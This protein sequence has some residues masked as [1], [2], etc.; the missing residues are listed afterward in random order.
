MF[1]QYHLLQKGTK[2]IPLFFLL[3]TVLILGGCGAQTAPK[4]YRVGIV[5]GADAFAAIGDGFKDKMTELGYN[6]GKNIVYDF[7]KIDADDAKL[8]ETLKKFVADKVDLIF[9]F[10]TGPALA[11]KAATAGTNIPVLFFA[12]V[13]GN[14]LIKDIREPGGNV[15][16][17]RFAG[18]DRALKRFDILLQLVPDIKHL[19]IVY[20]KKYSP[21]VS[22]AE[23]LRPLAESKGIKLTELDAASAAEVGQTLATQEQNDQTDLDAI[24]A[25]PDTNTQAPEGW[26]PIAEFAA[27]HKLPVAGNTVFQAK[28]GAIFAYIPDNVEVGTLAAPIADKILKGASAGTIPLFTPESRLT[29]NYKLA[30]ELGLTVPEGLLSQADEIIR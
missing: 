23:A 26:A 11:A 24:L 14:D 13:E 20:N 10:P 16:G 17:L 1:N 4:T 21:A 19:L 22:A 5:S 15:T 8:E 2:L 27:K 7:Q 30:Q 28:H 9:A 6:E 12:T 18:T 3:V 25:M 29:I